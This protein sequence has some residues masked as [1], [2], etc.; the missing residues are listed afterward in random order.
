MKNFL[1]SALLLFVFNL[2]SA[3]DDLLNQL[4]TAKPEEKEIE[5]SAFKGLQICNMQSTKMT[6]KGEWYMVVSH[7]FGDLTNGFNNF[8]G[9]DNALTKFGGIYGVT[10]W[11]SLGA[12]RHTLDKVYEV[13]AKYKLANQMKEGFPVTI[14]GYNTMDINSKLDKAVLPGLQFNN[15]LAFSTQLLVSRKFSDSF[16]LELN[17]IYI[18][19]NLY[20][21]GLEQKNEF[22]VGTGARY[23]VAKRMSV[24]LEYAA[25]INTIEGSKSP[26]QNP[27]T[28]GLDIE[29]GGHVFQLVLSNSQAMNDVAMFSRP[30]GDFF[31]GAIYFGFNMY[32]VF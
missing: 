17:P 27:I 2:A 14:V 30:S 8:F 28:L 11:L 23:K 24:N 12:S 26:F 19:K 15:R 22:F 4:D 32:R 25:R 5:T 21:Y 29:T 3:Q 18:H 16:S 20:E 10:D 1:C 31:G 7:R 13:T 6:S 9:L